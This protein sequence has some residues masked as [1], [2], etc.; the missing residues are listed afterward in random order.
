M[1]VYNAQDYLREAIESILGQTFRNFE[2]L[3]VNDGSTDASREIVLSYQDPRI[4]LVDNPSNI[5]LTRS[6][7]RGLNM[8]RGR[9][10]ARQ[11]ADDVSLPERM[12][13]QI[14]FIQAH[15][16]RV[17][18]GAQ[19]EIMDAG[20]RAVR[21]GFSFKPTTSLGIKW[22]VLFG[23]PFVHSS[24]LF[25]KNIIWKELGGYNEAFKTSQDFELWSRLLLRHTGRNLTLVLVR[26]RRHP[27]NISGN[28]P[29]TDIEMVRKRII[30]N[31][32]EI[33]QWNCAPSTWVDVWV[34]VNN[35]PAVSCPAAPKEAIVSFDAIYR[36][37]LELHPEGATNEDLRR[38]AAMVA[39]TVCRYYWK[40]CPA[41]AVTMLRKSMQLHSRTVL[42]IAGHSF[43]RTVC[44]EG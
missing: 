32:C 29:V 18:V 43:R 4:R 31:L 12:A 9:W 5:G 14:E 38:S 17:I 28:Y 34:G 37:F 8:A 42:R 24:V 15:P 19:A 35:A 41:I 2:F 23:S 44:C 30:D 36:R 26:T 33:L 40:R 27:G 16:E 39:M 25:R 3:I 7:N 11:D 21:T 20:G 1:S 22:G 13:R 6:L 10:I